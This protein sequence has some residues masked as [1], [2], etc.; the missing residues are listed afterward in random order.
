MKKYNSFLGAFFS[1]DNGQGGYN[2]AY[3]RSALARLA[4]PAADEAAKMEAASGLARVNPQA[5][6]E[7]QADNE[8]RNKAMVADSARLLVSLGKDNPLAAQAWQTRIKPQL[9]KM[10]GEQAASLPDLPDDSIMAYAQQLAGAGSD[11]PTDVRSIEWKLQQAGYQPG[12]PEYK[13]ALNIEL[14]LEARPS[15]A[16]IAYKEVTGPDGRK[17]WVAFDPN[18]VGATF[19]GDDTQPR[20][21]SPQ[22][23]PPV[24]SGGNT[25]VT[26]QDVQ[27]AAMRTGEVMAWVRKEIARREANGMPA[28]QA[29]S[30]VMQEVARQRGLTLPQG[31][32][33]AHQPVSQVA[34]PATVSRFAP[35]AGPNMFTSRTP[36]ENKAA[37]KAAEYQVQLQYEAEVA[38][39]RAAAEAEAKAGVEM[40]TA[41]Q[42]AGATESAKEAA[43]A[44]AQANID[45]PKAIATAD[46]TL[47]VIDKAINHPGREMATG[48]SS[49]L[50]W[51]YLPGTPG[52]D[53]MAVQRQLEGKTF[54]QAF[55]SLKGGGAITQIEGDKATQAIARLDTAQSEGEYLAA[56]KELRQ[57]VVS[58]RARAQ[59]KLRQPAPQAPA[60]TSNP[61]NNSRQALLDKY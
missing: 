33:P 27:G 46:D 43:K 61:A 25:I 7:W 15:S 10:Y 26:P 3:G 4:D 40:R 21:N 53:F 36:E 22:V 6:M 47:A 51:S 35:P 55:E 28:D 1:G 56:L 31:G 52:R 11:K 17:R 60:R 41:P 59:A 2:A 9:V 20:P 32:Q 5:A 37:E 54:L 50:P 14:G 42:I 45:A 23:P 16:A 8:T 18:E 48:A 38:A 58:A 29:T 39:R 30:Q 12:S 19:V 57:I 34:P 44:Q 49:A 13:K 24:S